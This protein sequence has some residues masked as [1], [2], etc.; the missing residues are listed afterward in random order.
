MALCFLAWGLFH[1]QLH[2]RGI[3]YTRHFLWTTAYFLAVA[4]LMGVIF[5]PYLAPVVQ[6]FALLPLVILGFFVATQV[7]FFIYIPRRLRG[8][9]EYFE[10]Y[11]DRY[12]LKI[13]WRRLISKSADIAAQQVFVV[14]LLVFLKD[15]GLSIYQII[16]SFLFLFALLHVPLIVRE[17][18]RWP[19]WL[20]AGAVLVFGITFPP[21]ILYVPYGLVYTYII[22]WLFYMLTAFI[23]WVRHDKA[24]MSV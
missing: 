12:Y 19:S 6:D 16:G 23:F 17:R 11:P 9:R 2:S 7:V 15:A 24:R 21:L 14:L 4:A 22:H 3:T 8:P 20:F 10:R 1:T 5:W 18:G 13:D